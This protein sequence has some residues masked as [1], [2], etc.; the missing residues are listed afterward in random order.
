VCAL[1]HATSSPLHHPATP[2]C[3]ARSDF[4]SPSQLPVES[5]MSNSANESG[6]YFAW[7][8]GRSSTPKANTNQAIPPTA[9]GDASGL[10][11]SLTDH[12]IS[13]I[14]RLSRREYPPNCPVLSTQWYHAVDV[15]DCS[16]MG[17][18]WIKIANQTQFRSPK[19]SPSP[20]KQSILVH[21][22]QLQRNIF[23]SQKRIPV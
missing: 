13:S 22:L 10:K 17:E 2:I 1:Q 18:V 23:H 3:S 12:A 19:E 21:Q 5:D 4:T 9:D 20:I 8:S 7:T 16:G 11:K 14:N 15:S 6:S